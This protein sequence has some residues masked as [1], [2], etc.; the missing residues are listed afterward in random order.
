[1]DYA[2]CKINNAAEYIEDE[3]KLLEVKKKDGWL[4]ET[5]DFYIKRNPNIEYLK[6]PEALTD[7]VI[8][9][10]RDALACV[11]KASIY[12]QRV[13]WLTSGDDGYESFCLR[14]D[15][16]LKDCEEHGGVE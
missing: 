11:R 16:E 4:I 6:T 12:A 5:C 10:M 9:R 3:L 13:E 7:A 15:Q 1:M 14:L 2:F 8:S